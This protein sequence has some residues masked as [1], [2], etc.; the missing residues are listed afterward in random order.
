MDNKEQIPVCP[1]AEPQAVAQ[2]KAEGNS[3]G[4]FK[5]K[6]GLL[7]AYNSLEAEFTRRSQ[8][9]KEL[10]SLFNTR[11]AEEKW[12][13]KVGEL[14]EKYPVAKQFTAEI[15][16]V[17]AEKKELLED[18]NCLEKALLAVLSTRYQAPA[19][20]KTD[21][22]KDKPKPHTVIST[23][24]EK[25][26]AELKNNSQTVSVPK[27]FPPGGELPAA[28]RVHASTVREAGDLAR[29]LLKTV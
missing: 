13:K 17:I 14:T 29:K 26:E 3:Y 19:P 27:V 24:R 6:E 22:E 16:E 28:P 9:I 15:G 1:S 12:N 21:T 11:E 5:T 25:A 18:E 4:K 8:R 20:I 7:E 2:D 23:V 10:E